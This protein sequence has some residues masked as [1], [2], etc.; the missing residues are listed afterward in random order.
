MLTF[1]QS[2]D[3]VK[4]TIL[5]TRKGTED[6]PN[7][8]HSLRVNESLKKYNFDEDTQ[9]AWLLHD[10]IEDGWM[11]FEELKELGYSD[12]IL[13]LVDLATHD[14]TIND[15]MEKRQKMLKRLMEENNKNA[16]AIKLADI[17]DNLL[18]CHLMP[19]KEKLDRF[20]NKKCPVFIY[21]GNKYFAWTEFYNEF[22]QRYYDQIKKFNDYFI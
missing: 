17:S 12:E 15:S 4:S 7:Y 16:W 1:Q 6:I 2:I 5:W 9:M 19:N 18:E 8:L 20:L 22:L 10:I 11:T 21:Y 13:H 14:M 3:L